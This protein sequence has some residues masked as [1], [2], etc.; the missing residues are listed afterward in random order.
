MYNWLLSNLL[1]LPLVFSVSGAFAQQAARPAVSQASDKTMRA[2]RVNPAPPTIDG[3]LN[4]EAWQHTPLFSD[5]T[6]HDPDEGKAPTE[7]TTVQIVYDDEAVYIGVQCYDSKAD[8]IASRLTRRDQWLD[9]DRVVV[10]L[11]PHYDHQTGFFF[12]L[13]PSVWK[14]ASDPV[15]DA[16]ERNLPGSRDW[17]SAT[18]NP[19]RVAPGTGV[20]L[21]TV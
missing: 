9:M 14:G 20:L 21:F 19:D 1:L 3:I 15:H 12:A 16:S 8:K 11:D 18:G 13:G 7:S 17:H 4:D 2:T 10:S 6:Q 5:F